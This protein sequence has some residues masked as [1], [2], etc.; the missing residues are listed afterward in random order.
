[1]GVHRLAAGHGRSGGVGQLA[2]Q[3]VEAE[4]N[5][6]LGDFDPGKPVPDIVDRLTAEIEGFRVRVLLDPNKMP[7]ERMLLADKDNPHCI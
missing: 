2:G 7:R 6:T 3:P 5:G 1:V 4:S